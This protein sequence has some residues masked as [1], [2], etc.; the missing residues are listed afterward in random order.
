MEIKFTE[1]GK[2]KGKVAVTGTLATM[3]KGETWRTDCTQVDPDYL[4][5]AC[6]RLGRQTGAQFT[7]SHTLQMDGGI[8]VTRT[9]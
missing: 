5:I 3:R 7:V 6:T 2:S 8:T 1:K 4:R 9:E